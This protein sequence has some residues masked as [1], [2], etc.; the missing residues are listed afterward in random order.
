M[1]IVVARAGDHSPRLDVAAGL[2]AGII[3]GGWVSTPT[4]PLAELVYISLVRQ[5][6]VK[7]KRALSDN[8]L[9]LLRKEGK[10][11]FWYYIAF[12]VTIG[13]CVGQALEKYFYEKLI[14]EKAGPDYRTAMF[15]KGKP[16]YVVSEHEYVSEILGLKDK[17]GD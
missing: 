17:A 9:P 14:I 5:N 16:Y 4:L 2:M 8:T 10:R 11:M 6:F 13:I 3:C 15:V 1:A 12:A 7:N